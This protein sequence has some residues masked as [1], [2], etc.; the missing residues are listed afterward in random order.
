MDEDDLD[1]AP[2]G[3]EADDNEGDSPHDYGTQPELLDESQAAHG[4]PR[5]SCSPIGVAPC[6]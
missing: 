5:A 1:A 4:F 6:V 3:D 2:R